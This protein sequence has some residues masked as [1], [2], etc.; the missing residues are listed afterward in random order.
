[1]VD[2]SFVAYGDWSLSR[3]AFTFAHEKASIN[4]AAEQIFGCISWHRPVIP[5]ELIEAVDWCDVVTWNPANHFAHVL[6]VCPFS[7]LIVIQNMYLITCKKSSVLLQSF[8]KEHNW[9]RE[10]TAYVLKNHCLSANI[11][12][13]KTI[14]HA[15]K[16]LLMYYILCTRVVSFLNAAVD[17]FNFWTGTGQRVPVANPLTGT[18]I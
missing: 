11:S 13:G 5:R 2:S 4:A 15:N 10:T 7:G 6:H 17:P 16:Y 18:Q 3:A 9:K 8:Y 14:C 1:M 12:M